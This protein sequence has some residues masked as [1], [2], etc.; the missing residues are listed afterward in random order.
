M[1]S[2]FKCIPQTIITYLHSSMSVFFFPLLS[3]EFYVLA[4]QMQLDDLQN[5][6]EIFRKYLTSTL[7][8]FQMIF[9]GENRCCCNS[10]RFFVQI[11]LFVRSRA[12]FLAMAMVLLSS[13]RIRC[14]QKKI[15]IYFSITLNCVRT[16]ITLWLCCVIHGAH[17]FLCQR[18]FFGP[19]F[20]AYN[21]QALALGPLFPLLY[22]S[23]L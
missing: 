6:N 16:V 9:N 4:S 18:N 19:C 13:H 21:K 1:S 20:G 2:S 17:H 15:F 22:L 5:W 12:R 14:Q 8:N 3:G 11:F 7:T 10:A 23:Y